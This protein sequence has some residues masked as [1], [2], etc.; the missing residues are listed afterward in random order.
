MLVSAI[1]A[2]SFYGGEARAGTVTDSFGVVWH[3]QGAGGGEGCR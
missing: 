1:A 3:W 2:V